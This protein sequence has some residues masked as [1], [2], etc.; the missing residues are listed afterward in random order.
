MLANLAAK[1]AEEIYN[2]RLKEWEAEQRSTVPGSGSDGNKTA[3][4]AHLTWG[5]F[6]PEPQLTVECVKVYADF[7]DAM[8]RP[9]KCNSTAYSSTPGCT[10]LGDI[11]EFVEDNPELMLDMI[12]LVLT[13]CGLAPVVGEACDGVAAGV[14]FARGDWIGGSLSVVSV[15]PGLGWGSAA[16]KLGDKFRDVLRIFEELATKCTKRSS[17]AP[18]TRVLLADGT[19]KPIE[20]LTEGDSVLSTDP[21]ARIRAPRTITATIES[22]GLKALVVITVDVDG[23][24]GDATGTLT[25]TY[26][27]PFWTPELGTWTEADELVPGR[28]LLTADGNEVEVESISTR[29]EQATVHNI[30]VAD[31]STYYVFAGDTPVLVHNCGKLDLDE[32]IY[33]AHAKTHVG[34]SES[35]LKTRAK[36]NKPASSLDDATAQ[37]TIDAVLTDDVRKTLDAWSNNEKVQTGVVRHIY[38]QPFPHA[39]GK[40]V[41]KDAQG[42]TRTEP[43]HRVTLV[44]KKLP[45]KK[46][47]G[48]KGPRWVLF[49]IEAW[50]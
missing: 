26:N 10:M 3:N 16:I 38:S 22:S 19:R 2:D 42:N 35:L 32:G 50:D 9:A 43:A 39:V 7:A 40:V 21:Q 28:A 29:T 47:Q 18:G 5:C 23:D 33:G 45:P 34:I 36:P 11:Q 14:A 12:E 20:E 49:T 41:Y 44:I 46:Y 6:V 4:E 27:H 15:L 31:L 8:M 1:E 37:A 13:L 17:F 25:A 24:K 48:H 30:T